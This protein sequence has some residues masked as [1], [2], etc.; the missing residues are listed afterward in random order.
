MP[1]P[2]LAISEVVHWLYMEELACLQA[3]SRKC[4]VAAA[5]A[6]RTRVDNFCKA[7][8]QLPRDMSE[9]WD[10][11]LTMCSTHQDGLSF[12]SARNSITVF[13]RLAVKP[14][15]PSCL[16][17]GTNRLYSCGYRDEPSPLPKA[18][19]D[20]WLTLGSLIDTSLR[21]KRWKMPEVRTS[22]MLLLET[23]PLHRFHGAYFEVPYGSFS[24]VWESRGGYS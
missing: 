19:A 24:F 8:W 7:I 3:S 11:S 4:H 13:T 9:K 15:S 20:L 5:L 2:R 23:E 6:L 21:L 16:R 10:T 18:Y 12:H 22:C 17:D 1:I 14:L